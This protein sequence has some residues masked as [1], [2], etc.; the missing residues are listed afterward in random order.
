MS[1]E[2]LI[3][4]THLSMEEHQQLNIM[5]ENDLNANPTSTSTNIDM[6]SQM[7][8]IN[9]EQNISDQN[10]ANSSSENHESLLFG[11]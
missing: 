6:D 2:R 1:S 10:F 3:L 8:N 5:E 4:N 7:Y 11:N 9:L